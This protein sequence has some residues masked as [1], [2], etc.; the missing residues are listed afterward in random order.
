MSFF[1]LRGYKRD[2]KAEYG[3][4]CKI[5]RIAKIKLKSRTFDS[6]YYIKKIVYNKVVWS[7]KLRHVKSLFHFFMF[8]SILQTF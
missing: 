7:T 5:S 8:C 2:V 6:V 4:Q 1:N 3:E